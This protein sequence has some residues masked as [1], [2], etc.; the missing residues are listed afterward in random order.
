MLNTPQK[1]LETG[2][3]FDTH[4]LHAFGMESLVVPYPDLLTFINTSKKPA[5]IENV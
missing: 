1:P 3:W 2:A 5:F 4:N